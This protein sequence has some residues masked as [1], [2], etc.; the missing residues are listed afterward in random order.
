EFLKVVHPDDKDLVLQQA[1]KKQ[2]GCPGQR[3]N[4]SFRIVSKSGEMKWVEIYSRTVHYRDRPANLLT[5]LDITDRK[6]SEAALRR[7]EEKYR[8]LFERAP[9]GIVSVDVDGRITE[10]NEALA[11]IHGLPSV[12]AVKSVNVLKYPPLVVSG[13]SEMFRRCMEGGG[14]Q[15]GEILYP[16][17]EGNDLRLRL[18]ATPIKNDDDSV[19]GLQAVVEDVTERRRAEESLRE[20]EERYRVAA[21]MTGQL[22]YDCDCITKRVA[23]AGA[24]SNITGYGTD[25]FDKVDMDAWAEMI[26]PEDRRSAMDGLTEAGNAASPFSIQ[27]RFR[28]RDGEYVWVEDTGSFLVGSDGKPY[29][30]LGAVKEITERRL[31]HEALIQALHLL[32][33]ILAASPAA[34]TY[35][36]NGTIVWTN[37]SM[38]GMYGVAADNEVLG[39][40]ARDFYYSKEEYNRV[41]TLFKSGMA[42][43][44]PLET[45]AL[46]RKKDGGALPCELRVAPV[47]LTSGKNCLIS[48]VL[49]IS[50]RVKAG[51]E[52]HKSEREFRD[53][54]VESKRQSDLYRSLLDSSPD[55]V[56]I[57]DTEGR[58]LYVNDSFTGMF[59]WT[60]EEI[61]N[62]RIPYVPDSEREAGMARIA[63]LLNDGVPCRGF[64]TKRC[65][66]DGRLL[67]ISLSASRYHKHDGTPAGMLVVLTD[68]TQG[69]TLEERL[70][71]S[72]KMEAIGLLAGGIAHDF[73][74]ILTAIIGYAD[75]LTHS[76]PKHGPNLDRLRQITRSA[77]KAADLTRQ[78]LAFSRKQVLDMKVHSLNEIIVDVEKLLRRLIVEDIDVV[79][80]LDPDP[81]FILADEVQIQQILMNL[82]INARD[83]VRHRGKVTIETANVL[84]D[85]KYASMQPDV[86]PG[87]YVMLS[88]SDDGIGMDPATLSRVFEPFFTTKEKGAGTGLGLAT[89]YGI[90]KQHRG[91][92]TVYS[93]Q[94]QGT[95]FKV[96]LPRATEVAGRVATQVTDVPKPHGVETVLIVEDEDCVRQLVCEALT[97]LGYHTLTAADPAEALEIGD[98]YSD[99]IHL[100]LSDVVLPQMDGKSLYGLLAANRPDLKVIYASGYTEDFIVH[101]GILEKDIHFLQ[102]PFN[103]DK[104]AGMVRAVLDA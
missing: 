54:Y 39:K 47:Q 89:V 36:E 65:T 13:A 45:E 9:V 67:N 44:K 57:Y 91:H 42:A 20:R 41:R 30:I 33:T 23:W 68:I 5:M 17:Q 104:L 76:L 58:A 4:Y 71:Q 86:E 82:V 88:V 37:P 85:E 103:V 62:Q 10:A 43:G 12:E 66:K 84:L 51:E 8:L 93:E 59:G 53:L 81:G 83:A 77:E 100:L 22:I 72:A 52:L 80:V 102:K 63:S 78:L 60:M 56:V 21:L 7:S 46:F 48:V 14:I 69:K 64:E 61:R 27:Y 16:S 79:T 31:A 73:N 92:I 97:M 15:A 98:S 101:H 74:N 11:R 96:F 95:V 75:M 55:A 6:Q 90:V 18:I 29:R 19:I 70:R 40:P 35:I 28:R 32:R 26:H 38:L 34:I 99:R 49:D 24:V 94:G 87:Q 2:A 1:R 3:R 50:A 25:E